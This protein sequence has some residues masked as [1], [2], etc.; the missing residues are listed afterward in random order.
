MIII[1]NVMPPHL[2]TAD[3]IYLQNVT[4]KHSPWK[5]Y[6][7]LPHNIPRPTQLIRLTTQLLTHFYPPILTTQFTH[8]QDIHY[9]CTH[10]GLRSKAH[11]SNSQFSSKAQKLLSLIQLRI[12]RV[13]Q[14][15]NLALRQQSPVVYALHGNQ[16]VVSTLN[17]HSGC[18]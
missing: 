16:A 7:Y 1:D 10:A 13:T 3:K 18:T 8:F 11:N 15:R 4:L 5:H 14:H 2:T 9:R 12:T 17:S 6:W